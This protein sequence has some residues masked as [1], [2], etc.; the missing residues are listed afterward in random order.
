MSKTSA[1]IY[2]QSDRWQ[3]FKQEFNASEE[4]REFMKQRLQDE[5]DD[6][7]VRKEELQERIEEQEKVFQEEKDKLERLRSELRTVEETIKAREEA[8]GDLQ[9]KLNKAVSIL[10]RK[11]KDCKKTGDDW[12]DEKAVSYWADELEMPESKL[13]EKVEE[14][15]EG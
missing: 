11:R 15:V 13:I 8:K 5:S 3:R 10:K 2:V 9:E 12:R 6:L 7:E 4:I 1:R 14:E